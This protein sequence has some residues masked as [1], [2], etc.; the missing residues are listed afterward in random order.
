MRTRIGWVAAILVCT[1]ATACGAGSSSH[2]TGTRLT[3]SGIARTTT[4]AGTARLEL[5]EP[6][7]AN[8]SAGRPARVDVGTGEVDLAHARGVLQG[9]TLGGGTYEIRWIGR[10]FYLHSTVTP[11]PGA[12][13]TS[14]KW[15]ES[16]PGTEDTVSV[17]PLTG[18]L[19]TADPLA[20]LRSSPATAV[21]EGHET[22]RGV[23]TTHLRVT[24]D[25][26]ALATRLRSLGYTV[27]DPGR[28]TEPADLWVDAQGR[29]R[30]MTSPGRSDGATGT[31]TLEL[32]DY[33]VQVDVQP[34]PADQIGHGVYS[35]GSVSASA[36]SSSTTST[37]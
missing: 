17:D 7:A 20:S 4:A 16:G 25:L 29:L 14:G 11:S 37:P 9:N 18:F 26:A 10:H 6:L 35:S 2:A 3:A 8:P 21:M 22:V 33:G 13:P 30:R 12:T 31:I 32:F 36:T 28:A 19:F 24:L 1:F 23:A 5:R 27:D 15:I 34:P